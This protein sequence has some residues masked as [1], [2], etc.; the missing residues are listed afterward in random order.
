MVY[1]CSGFMYVNIEC[2]KYSNAAHTIQKAIN[3]F[4]YCRFRNANYSKH[5][6]M[7]FGQFLRKQ[8][9]CYFP[10]LT[11]SSYRMRKFS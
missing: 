10:L 2:C 8:A 9:S 7:F 4:T 5:Y 6:R 11:N 3:R 1:R